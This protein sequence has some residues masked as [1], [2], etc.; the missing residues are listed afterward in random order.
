M[1]DLPDSDRIE[2]AP[3]PRDTVRLFGHDAA[4]TAFLAAHAADRLH[5]GWLVTG[6]EGIGKATLAY[7][8]AAFLLADPGPAIFGPPATL[9]LPADDPDLRLIRAGSHPRLFVLK[10]GLN[11]KGDGW[12]SQITVDEARRLKGFFQMSAADGGRRAVIIDA[13]DE[14]NVSAANAIL[15]VLEEPPARTPRSGRA[16]GCCACIRWRPPVLPPRWRRST[17]R[18]PGRAC[19]CLPPDRSAPRCG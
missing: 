11:D 17:A 4:E 13:A 2:G 3:H 10:R 14:M 15:K 19:R 9:D 16:A 7:R 6:P 5:S 1:T 18:Q 8:I 12:R